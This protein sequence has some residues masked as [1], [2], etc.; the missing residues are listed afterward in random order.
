MGDV[1]NINLVATLVGELRSSAG[2][3]E[4]LAGV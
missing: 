4:L 3:S 1:E 2:L